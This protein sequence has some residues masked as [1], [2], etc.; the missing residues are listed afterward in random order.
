MKKKG[1][2]IF[3][4]FFI[5]IFIQCDPP[6]PAKLNTDPPE[7][8][9]AFHT[10]LQQDGNAFNKYKDLVVVLDKGMHLVFSRETGYQPKWITP[11]S[12]TMIEDLAPDRDPDPNFDYTYVRLIES[13][14]E[15]IVVHW[16][17][18]PDIARLEAANEAL[19]PLNIHGFQGAVHE[20][21]DPLNIHGFQG[22]VHEVFTVFPDYKVKRE[23]K[24]AEGVR[25]EDWN[26]PAI[27]TRQ[28]IK[29]TDSGIEHGEVNWGETGPFYPRPAAEGN[30]I[31]VP[32][33][34]P[35]LCWTFD[36]GMEPHEDNVTE[37]VNGI[38]SMIEGSR[39]LFKKGVSGTALGFDGYYTGVSLPASNVPEVTG[40]FTVEAWVALDAWY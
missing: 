26:N 14:P 19:D 16:R 31:K 37:S 7:G 24:M 13:G 10:D 12:E 28:E 34:K 40:P 22:A 17:Y 23:L 18:I 38:S 20:V 4:L 25:F 3:L 21:L 33:S 2:W 11:S 39:T 9:Y 1:K 36:E 27:V 32:E 6:K 35:A 30:G 15:K 5:P 29:L 8:F